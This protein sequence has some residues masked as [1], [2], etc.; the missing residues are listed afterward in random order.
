M[1]PAVAELVKPRSAGL[2]DKQSQALFAALIG[3][4]ISDS[5]QLWSEYNKHVVRRNGVVHDGASVDQ[6]GADESIAVV[7]RLIQWIEKAAEK[8]A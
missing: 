6:A 4:R 5:G 3:R 7:R 2:R 1:P 8:H